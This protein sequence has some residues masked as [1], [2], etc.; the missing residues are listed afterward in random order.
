MRRALIHLAWLGL[1]VACGSDQKP[2]A[3]SA[4]SDHEERPERSGGSGIE[5]SAE[6]GALES[7]IRA[8]TDE[9]LRA[10]TLEFRDRLAQGE[11]L[12]DLLVDQY[13]C[14]FS[15]FQ[16]MLDHWAIDQLFPIMPIHR[17]TD[18]PTRRGRS[19]T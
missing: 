2:E 5:A 6:I 1:L 7:T 10:K 14:D 13:L 17:L 15:V 18:Q 19:S 16:S 9:Q 8:L 12:D 4:D 3:K 11:T